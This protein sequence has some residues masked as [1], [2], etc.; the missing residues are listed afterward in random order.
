MKI[1]NQRIVLS[2]SMILILASISNC[3]KDPSG[4][5]TTG[6][7]GSIDYTGNDGVAEITAAPTVSPTSISAG[8]SVTVKV[9]V[10]SDTGY[11][12]VGFYDLAG[13]APAAFPSCTSSIT[14]GTA[15]TVTLTCATSVSA[16]SGDYAVEV[17]VAPSSGDYFSG[18]MTSYVQQIGS[19]NYHRYNISGYLPD[20][21]TATQASLAKVTVTGGG[22]GG[23][24]G[25]TS[26]GSISSPVTL[27]FAS[28]P[29]TSGQANYSNSYYKITGLTIGNV[30]TFGIS[31]LS[32]DLDLSIYSSNAGGFLSGFL[33][34]SGAG[35]TTSES[36]SFTATT[37]TIYVDV[38]P[39]LYASST[40]TLTGVDNG[41][42]L[43][44]EGSLTTP[45]AVTI[46][47]PYT[48]ASVSGTQDSFYTASGL[49]VGNIYQVN[50]TNLSADVDLDLY[51][52]NTAGTWSGWRCGSYNSG[53]A[54]ETCSFLATTATAYL[55]INELTSLGATFTIDI[56]DMG[57]PPVSEGTNALPI[58]IPFASLPY[59][60]G[61]VAPNGQSYYV[62]SSLT[63]GNAYSIDLTGLS[64]N[65]DLDLY[66]TNTAGTWS[67]WFCGSYNSQTN[68]ESCTFV[69]TSTNVYVNVSTFTSVGATFTISGTD[70]GVAPVAE[71]TLATPVIIPFTSL[72]YTTG[73]VSPTLGS[74]YEVTGLTI[75][76]EYTISLSA[77]TDNVNLIV[78][79]SNQT[80]AWRG[81]YC[82]SANTLT[83]PDSCS[84]VA[85]TTTALV[86]AKESTTVGG[87]FTI[88]GVDNG[89][90]VTA[91]TYSEGT[92]ANPKMIPYVNLPYTAGSVSGSQDSYY[93]ITGLTAGN[94]YSVTLTAQ[95]DMM[96]LAVYKNMVNGIL[97]GYGCGSTVSGN[98]IT[99]S[100][101][102]ITSGTN[103][104]VLI[105]DFT[106]SGGTFTITAADNGPP[107]VSEGTWATP[108]AIPLANMPYSTGSVGPNGSSY[109]AIT[110]LTVGVRYSLSLYNISEDL[111]VTAYNE[112]I[113]TGQGCSAGVAV[114]GAF[115]DFIA[116]TPVVYVKV[117]DLSAVGSI[118]GMDLSFVLVATPGT[119]Q[120]G[121]TTQRYDIPFA[122]LPFAN[123]SVDN[124]FGSEYTLSG[125]TV[126]NQYT[127]S[128]S[129]IT[130][131]VDLAVY[132]TYN[133]SNGVVSKLLC[134]SANS[135]TLNEDC[136][137]VANATSVYF[138]VFEYTVSGA[139]YTISGVDNGLPLMAAIPG[140][141]TFE[142]LVNLPVEFYGPTSAKWSVDAT[143]GGGSPV[144]LNS[145]KSGA[146]LDN[147]IS[148]TSVYTNH[149]AA[150]S[151]QFWYKVDSELSWDKLKFYIDD[152]LQ[153]SWSG[154]VAW[155]QSGVYNLAIGS[156][157]LGWCYEK[158]WIDSVGADA[159][160]IDEI[161]IQ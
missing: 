111:R 49:T 114:Y 34:S 105:T 109:Y 157:E 9:P 58:D 55:W 139:T 48:T 21:G 25:I 86:F 108:V 131:N 27:S 156:H 74:Y 52:T 89:V 7:G 136:T 87:T 137:F 30:Y 133:A 146:I 68:A 121:S 126:G 141:Y 152:V 53:T 29:Y 67:G 123:G 104:Y 99:Y 39:F 122:N 47:V 70:Y 112:T 117:D 144:T 20:G 10:D 46:G 40:F 128:L 132:G 135:G 17:V 85:N 5:G 16:T 14:A 80:T 161:I 75:G 69:A 66:D 78:Y 71:G 103:A 24:G 148:C 11:I 147:Q 107:P 154:A 102:F 143:T 64:A 3:K 95:S 26:E 2:L 8:G 149:A 127:L 61:S 106:A 129:S 94:V 81:I 45:I 160:W 4:P 41:L 90:P 79:S 91:G 138:R 155:T 57:L 150:G 76:N 72:P 98:I 118:F 124:A 50:L 19:N 145:I 119:Y 18:T 15:T 93:G 31:A 73:S 83:T 36:C 101:S 51:S 130:A 23:G 43:L 38:N 151:V 60:T 82:S 125:L 12:S 56:V 35:G 63:P 96:G 134:N 88:D 62:I 42:P 37:S 159:A 54:S 33:C 97:S 22:G 116:S 113:F 28:L 142:G 84:F 32:A 1:K 115:C 44:S 158:D 100:C 92:S 120:Q 65:V 59:T 110:G 77:M 140:N 13:Y 153:T 6:G